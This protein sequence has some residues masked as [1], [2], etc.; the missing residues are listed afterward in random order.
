MDLVKEIAYTF[1]ICNSGAWQPLQTFASTF[2]IEVLT[3]DILPGPCGG[4]GG[5][6]GL[7]VCQGLGCGLAAVLGVSKWI[8]I[9]H[10][11][12]VGSGV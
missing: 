10:Q 11:T 3:L 6:T 4:R 9:G 2:Q 5:G 12:R 7:A 1:V 8:R